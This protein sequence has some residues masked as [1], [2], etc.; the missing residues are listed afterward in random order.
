MAA[1]L[2]FKTFT[3]GEVLTAADT[4]GYL[5]QGINVFA[6]A[7]ARSAAITS[8]QE[9]QYSFLKDTNALEYYDGA[10]W[11]GAPVGDIT[12][13]TAGKGLTGGG[14]SGDVTLSLATTAKGDLVAGSGASTAAVLTVGSNGETLVADSSTSTGLRY[15]GSTAAGRNFAINGGFDIWQRGTSFT[16]NGSY[17]ADRWYFTYGGTV[18][19]AQETTVVQDGSTNSIK[20]TTGAA[21]SFGELYN[22]L[23]AAE[24]NFL[25][26][27]TIT[28]S[29]SVRASSAVAYTGSAVIG[30]QTNTT[31]NSQ[32]GGTWTEQSTSTQ[33]PSTSA[34]TRFSLTYSVPSGTKGLRVRLGNTATQASGTILYW[35]NIQIEVGSVATGF[36]RAGGTIQGELAAC[37]RYYYRATVGTFNQPFSMGQCYST[38][39]AFGVV[40]FPVTMRSIP[41]ALEQSGTATDYKLTT[42]VFGGANCSAVPTFNAAS[43]SNG[44]VVFTVASGIVAGNAVSL[45]SGSANGYLGWSAEL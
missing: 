34:W 17:T 19:A 43:Y 10:A 27:K 9:G 38:T 44:V 2:G 13:V 7:S 25:A 24:V 39:Q 15:Q 40:P 32:T 21:T 23:E 11:V 28:I 8:P 26:G 14:S 41:T 36:S 22:A 18:T 42:A 29:G 45:Q 20:L 6:N 4:N 16:T 31:A 37:Q 12:A 35:S 5:M 33:A 3:S 30:I 1:G